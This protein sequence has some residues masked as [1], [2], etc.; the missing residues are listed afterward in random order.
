M[1]SVVRYFL[2]IACV[3]ALAGS[4]ANAQ[5]LQQQLAKLGH[6]AAVG[7]VTPLLSGWGNDLNSAIYYSADLHGILGF[8]VGV[9]IAMSKFTDADKT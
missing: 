4:I 6:D 5:D 2:V 1:K 9:K 7:Y 3:V 8:D